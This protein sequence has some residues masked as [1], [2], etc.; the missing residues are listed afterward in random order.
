MKSACLDDVAA[1]FGAEGITGKEF[2]KQFERCMK[3]KNLSGIELGGR[4]YREFLP[5]EWRNLWERSLAVEKESWKLSYMVY[6]EMYVLF[7]DNGEDGKRIQDITERILGGTRKRSQ[8]EKEEI[9]KRWILAAYSMKWNDILNP[10]AVFYDM[11]GRYTEYSEYDRKLIVNTFLEC[12]ISACG[13]GIQEHSMTQQ[14]RLSI[15]NGWVTEYIKSTDVDMPYKKRALAA[16]VECMGNAYIK[17]QDRQI[18]KNR[19]TR[20]F[21]LAAFILSL[22][23]FGISAGLYLGGSG[24]RGKQY[25]G[26]PAAAVASGTAGG[27]EQTGLEEETETEREIG[28]KDETAAVPVGK[29]QTQAGI[30]EADAPDGA[31][32]SNAMMQAADSEEEIV[33]SQTKSIIIMETMTIRKKPSVEAEKIGKVPSGGRV[34]AM[35]KKGDWL[36]ICYTESG[37]EGTIEGYIHYSLPK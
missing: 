6:W 3:N 23:F 33:F 8:E 18:K 5:G 19:N 27:K 37:G 28:T 20:M 35:G 22:G 30:N 12:V 31:T 13:A 10:M 7:R 24:E 32:G 11:T 26:N 14:E 25:L 21:G 34:E 16:V 2:E 36:K 4:I 29:L 1:M 17:E 15:L 9:L